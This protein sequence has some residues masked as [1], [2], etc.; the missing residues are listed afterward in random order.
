[1]EGE[2]S[3]TRPAVHPALACPID[4]PLYTPSWGN[5]ASGA[6]EGGGDDGHSCTR[7]GAAERAK[8]MS[9]GM[10]GEVWEEGRELGVWDVGGEGEEHRGRGMGGRQ[11]GLA[12]PQH[13]R[14]YGRCTARVVL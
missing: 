2:E 9:I 6:G 1:M 5:N 8:S 13:V 4:F 14:P 11:Y 3:K 10:C 7:W 12:V